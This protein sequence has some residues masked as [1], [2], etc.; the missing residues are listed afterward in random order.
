MSGLAVTTAGMVKPTV[1]RRAGG[2]SRHAPV[3]DG[4]LPDTHTA[5]TGMFIQKATGGSPPICSHTWQG[6]DS[7]LSPHPVMPGESES[8]VWIRT[9]GTIFAVGASR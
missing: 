1:G 4:L 5:V 2:N 9:R 7:A 3:R 8:R 6:A